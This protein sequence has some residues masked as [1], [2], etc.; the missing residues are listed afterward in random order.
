MP[1]DTAPTASGAAIAFNASVA[2]ALSRRRQDQ[3]QHAPAAPAAPAADTHP[4]T[5]QETAR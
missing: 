4:T 1:T 2:G 3:P 5:P